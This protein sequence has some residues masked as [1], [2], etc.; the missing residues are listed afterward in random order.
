MTYIPFSNTASTSFS[1][2]IAGVSY[3]S[4]V[5]R[6]N[7]IISVYPVLTISKTACINVGNFIYIFG[8][9]VSA[10]TQTTAYK[11]DLTLDT[12][13]SIA[14]LPTA[15]SV[16]NIEAIGTD[17]YLF[18]GTTARKYDTVAN[19]YSTLTA[20]PG[21]VL[22]TSAVVGQYIYV[23]GSASSSTALYRYDIVANSWSTLASI[24]ASSVYGYIFASD[25][26]DVYMFGQNNSYKYLTSSNTYTSLASIASMG[27]GWMYGLGTW[28]VILYNQKV[29]YV[30]NT[31]S[32]KNKN[33][34]FFNANSY[35][36]YG[37]QATYTHGVISYSITSNQFTR[38][39][40]YAAG[41][42]QSYA[43]G[44]VVTAGCGVKSSETIYL[45]NTYGFN[46]SSNTG[47]S[48]PNVYIAPRSS[49]VCTFNGL[50]SVYEAYSGSSPTTRIIN[51]TTQ[52]LAGYN[53][54]ASAAMISTG[55]YHYY[56]SGIPVKINDIIND[57]D[58]KGNVW[59]GAAS[60]TVELA[61][62][63]SV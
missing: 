17:I 12:Y 23:H 1:N 60:P 61:I 6:P 50:V 24:P 19:T 57:F 22:Y 42:S 55:I 28:D 56:K 29:L 26:T 62:I 3:E 44:P 11:Y 14:S 40:S 16:I 41:A 13:S 2:N 35:E 8:G 51:E 9:E 32:F 54:Y 15:G 39:A 30:D 52:S 5:G 18:Y 59:G 43:S 58:N 4:F 53:I 31:G 7:G 49:Y 37:S 38:R 21:A 47:V 33:T 45:F 48:T 27:G 46:G 25:G 20:P 36:S 34:F 63:K 10:V